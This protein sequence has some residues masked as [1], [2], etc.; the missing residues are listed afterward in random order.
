VTYEPVY[1]RTPRNAFVP[2]PVFVGIVAVFAVSGVM[3]WTNFGNVKFD[4][5]L[6]ILSGWLISLC[7][8][9]YAHAVLGYFS[10][11]LSV[12]ER[13]YLRL[14]PLKYTHPLLSIV[15]PVVMVVLGG[16][17]LPGGAVWIDHRHIRSKVRE[18]LISAAGPLTNVF[19]AIVVAFPFLIGFGPEAW[20]TGGQLGL[21]DSA[22]WQFWAALAT[23]AFLQV[24][25]SVLNFLP[26]PGLDGGGII[27]P[28]L[29]PAYQRAWNL[30][31]PWGILVLFLLLWQTEAG[32]WFFNGVGWLT[33]L[34]GVDTG[35]YAA[36][37]Q[38]MRFW[39]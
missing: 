34:L 36:G 8:H 6:F 21:S 5:F 24:S 39:Q 25:A 15:L 29:S 11:D 2:S 20:I 27:H 33:G 23:L 32:A 22:H 37:L 19:L 28:W 10:G 4:V 12:A 9:E 26:I 31:A 14:N 7:L 13:G 30:I 17:G 35:L 38:L 18:S 16:I 1:T 3:T